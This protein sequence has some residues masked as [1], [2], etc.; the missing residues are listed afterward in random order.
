MYKS[1][2]KIKPQQNA[3][4]KSVS[5]FRAF[6]YNK[7]LLILKTQKKFESLAVLFNEIF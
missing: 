6:I 3:T 7:Q 4:Y 2:K 1:L 5:R